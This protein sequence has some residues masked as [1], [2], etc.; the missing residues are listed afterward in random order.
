MVENSTEIMQKVKVMLVGNYNGHNVKTSGSVDLN[1]KADYSE[2]VNSVQALQM[3]NNDITVS[4]KFPDETPF[5]VGVFRL[6]Q[7]NFGHDGESKIKLNSMTDFVEM[8]NIN[9]LI[10]DERFL[11]RLTADV[12]IEQKEE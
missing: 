6:N 9:R 4:V 8:D 5:K 10:T 12:E 7:L 1:L 3:L 11:I 2:M